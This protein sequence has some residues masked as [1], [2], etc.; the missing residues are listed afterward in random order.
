MI[1]HSFDSAMLVK[2]II[3]LLDGLKILDFQPYTN[4]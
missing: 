3:E 1:I 2:I 4:L